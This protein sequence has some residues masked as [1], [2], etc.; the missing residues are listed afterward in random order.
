M[1]APPFAD[2]DNYF[3]D[4]EG[5]SGTATKNTTSNIDFAI[6][7]VDRYMHGGQLVLNN[8]CHG[9]KYNFQ[10]VDKDYVYAGISYPATYNGTAWSV[11]Q[12][13]GVVLKQFRKNWNVIADQNDQGTTNYNF[14]A[15]IPAN[16]YIR[17]VYTSV[18]T[19]ND[20]SVCPNFLLVL[21][22]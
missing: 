20:V 8:H 6:G 15:K 21:K 22:I 13:N 4:S 10:V 17:V 3:A 16:T 11:A 2:A 5:T 18:G 19:E 14:V 9:D 12:P 1:A 7:S